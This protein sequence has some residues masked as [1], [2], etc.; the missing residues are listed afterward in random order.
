MDDIYY[1]RQAL[2]L[3]ADAAKDGEVPVGCIIVCRDKIVGGAQPPGDG[4][5]RSGPRRN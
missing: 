1:M 5:N 3:A 4:Q 2:L